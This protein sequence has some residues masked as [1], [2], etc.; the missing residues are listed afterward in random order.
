MTRFIVINIISTPTAAIA[1][2]LFINAEQW[3]LET[4]ADRLYSF[5][6]VCEHLGIDPAFLRAGLQRW[7]ERRT[8][9]LAQAKVQ[10]W[11]LLTPSRL[12]AVGE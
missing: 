4:G 10:H 7:K 1:K 2:K 8:A 9:E 6:S 3:I 11:R 12:A 5:D